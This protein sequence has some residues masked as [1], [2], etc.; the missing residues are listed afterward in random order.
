MWTKI[1]ADWIDRK[2]RYY[3]KKTETLP[4]ESRN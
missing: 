1:L 3:Y 4:T 2:G